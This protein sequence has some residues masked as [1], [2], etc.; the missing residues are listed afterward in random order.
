MSK[1]LAYLFIVVLATFLSKDVFAGTD[2]LCNVLTTING[3][4]KKVGEVQ[5]K[6]S[7]KTREIMSKKISLGKIQDT[8][9]KLRE[10]AESTKEKAEK[11]KAFAENAKEKKEEM[12]AKYQELNALAEKQFAQANEAFAQGEAIY[13]EYEQKF[14]EYN[15]ESQVSETEVDKNMIMEEPDNKAPTVM[16][17]DMASSLGMENVSM[18]VKDPQ[19]KSQTTPVR[20][21]EEGFSEINT[22]TVTKLSK[23]TQA[24]IVSSA[25]KLADQAL[26]ES[27]INVTPQT[28][29]LKKSKIDISTKD[30]MEDISERKQQPV[31]KETEVKTNIN[32]KDQLTSKANKSVTLS[33]EKKVTGAVLSEAKK[34]SKISDN[35]VKFGEVK[36]VEKAIM[37]ANTSN[38]T[39]KVD[40]SAKSVAKDV[41]ADI[42]PKSKSTTKSR[43]LIKNDVSGTIKS[44]I[45]QNKLTV[46]EKANVR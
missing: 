26:T 45:R 17:S 1:K 37:K 38:K 20:A 3:T 33:G 25:S 34:Q 36:A 46:K 35:R 30:I 10:K 42:A 22:D 9:E 4:L 21:T 19:G 29:I 8:A 32:M 16:I 40:S 43:S 18:A 31:S 2:I 27:K 23:T 15:E 13:A 44:D 14:Q 39:V 11:V 12:M 41:S 5:N 7:G 28:E 6:I 24:D